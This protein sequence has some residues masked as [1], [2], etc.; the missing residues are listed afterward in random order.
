M[1]L[2]R[3]LDL[4]FELINHVCLIN[5]VP[6]VWCTIWSFYTT[7]L[8]YSLSSLHFEV[9]W[10]V[11]QS[12]ETHSLADWIVLIWSS[13][14]HD[15]YN[16]FQHWFS[17]TNELIKPARFTLMG[18]IFYCFLPVIIFKSEPI[19]WLEMLMSPHAELEISVC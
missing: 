16:P 5:H 9:R 7:A 4:Q 17:H 2:K 19:L 13:N 11:L 6:A 10:S 8:R 15:K 1:T 18:L 3:G 14:K 12:H